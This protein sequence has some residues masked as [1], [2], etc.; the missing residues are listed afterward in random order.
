MALAQPLLVRGWQL[1]FFSLGG[2]QGSPHVLLLPGLVW[3]S[4]LAV[5]H[6]WQEKQLLWLLPLLWAGGHVVLYAWRLPVTYQHG[7]YLLPAIPIWTLY[8]LAGMA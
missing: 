5:R 6:D 2:S 7:R 3:A 1:L 4:W 8:G